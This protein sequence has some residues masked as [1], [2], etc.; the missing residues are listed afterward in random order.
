MP[1]SVFDEKDFESWDPKIHGHHNYLQNFYVASLI[2]EC[3]T[4]KHYPLAMFRNGIYER[5][6]SYYNGMINSGTPS[7]SSGSEMASKIKKVL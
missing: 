3:G 7:S 2:D 6:R 4:N 5:G 1:K